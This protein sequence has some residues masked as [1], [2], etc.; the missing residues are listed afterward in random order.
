M[1]SRSRE[2]GTNDLET[3]SAGCVRAR[4]LRKGGGGRGVAGFEDLLLR[5]GGG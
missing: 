5:N 3:S 1:G 2:G 4:C